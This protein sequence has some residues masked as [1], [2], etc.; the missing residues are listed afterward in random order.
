LPGETQKLDRPLQTLF[1][2]VN[3]IPVFVRFLVTQI[4]TIPLTNS[5]GRAILKLEASLFARFS[6]KKLAR[7]FV[8]QVAVGPSGSL[9]PFGT[10]PFRFL[11]ITGLQAQRSEAACQGL[12]PKV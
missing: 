6:H 1:P 3:A 10:P 8:S 5:A 7:R 2:E 4:L 9:Y 11:T 12:L